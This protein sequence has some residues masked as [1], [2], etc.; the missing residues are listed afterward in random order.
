MC[1]GS[2]SVKVPKSPPAAERQALQLPK[3][4]VDPNKSKMMR[5]RRGMWASIFTSP[6]GVT[7]A[8]T[9]TGAGAGSSY[10]GG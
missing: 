5:R 8:P 2:P 3:E 1:I 7:G 4:L 6:Q 9:V 10:T